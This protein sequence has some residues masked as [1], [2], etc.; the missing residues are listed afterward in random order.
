MRIFLPLLLSCLP[1]ILFCQVSFTDSTN[2]LEISNQNSGSPMGVADMNSDGLDDII[3]LDSRHLLYIHY[4]LLDTP[5]FHTEFIADLVGPKWSLCVADADANGF[6]D[7]F[8][9]G[10]YDGLYLLKANNNG[11]GFNTTVL[12]DPSIF[13]QGSNFADIDND[14]D[15]DIFACHDEGLSVPFANDGS[16]N[17]TADFNLILPESTIPSDNSGNYGSVWTDYD[18]D[19]DLDLYISKCRQGVDNPV[20][21]R[22]L[23]LLF[24][25]DGNNNYSDVATQANLQPFAQSWA[26]DFGDIDNDGDLDCF[27]IN[28]DINNTLHRN[29]GDGTFTDISLASNINAALNGAGPGLQVKFADFD[30]DGLVDLLFTSLGTSH[31]LLINNG[32]NTFTAA[33]NPF[34]EA[35]TRIHSAAVGDLNNDGFLDVYAGFGMSYNQSSDKSDRLFINDG[36]GNHY[37]KARLRGIESNINGIGAR[38]ELYGS[39]GKQIREIRSGES[40]GIMNSFTAHFGLGSATSIDSLIIRWPSGNL[41]FLVNPPADTTIFIEEGDFCLPIANFQYSGPGLALDFT[42]SGDAEVTGWQWDFGDGQTGSGQEISHTFPGE[43]VYTVCLTTSGGCGQAEYCTQVGVSCMNPLAG[44]NYGVD[45]L[46]ISFEDQSFGNPTQWLWDFGDGQASSEQNPNHGYDTIGVYFVCLTASNECSN[47]TFCEFIQA[48]C[49]SVTTAFDFDADGLSVQFIDYSSAGTNE[50]EWDFGDGAFSYEE[51]PTHDFPMTGSYEVC[52]NIRGVCGQGQYCRIIEVSCPPPEAAFNTID[53]ELAI[54]FEDISTNMPTAWSWDFGDGGNSTEEM[55]VHTYAAPGTYTACLLAGSPCGQDSI[56]QDIIVTCNAPQAG[57]T[58]INDELSATFTDTSTNNPTSLLWIVEGQDSTTGP[59]LEYDF[60]SPGN[61][62]ICLQAGS[63][64]GMTETCQTVEINCAVLQPG[65]DYQTEG[66]RLTFTDT[67]T[68]TATSW[69]WDFGDG[70]SSN[71]QDPVHDYALPGDYEVCLQISNIC[72]ETSSICRILSIDC[73][74]PEAGFSY[75]TNMLAIYLSDTSSNAPTQW[76]W[77]FGDGNSSA[78]ENPQHIYSGPGTYEVCVTAISPCGSSQACSMVVID[79]AEPVS[80]FM[81]ESNGLAVSLT[82]NSLNSPTQWLW[83]FGDNS[84]STEQNPQH[85]YSAPGNYVI[86]LVTTSV[87]GTDQGCRQVSISCI[88]PQ[89]SFSFTADGLSLSFSDQSANNPDGW[90]WTFG[91]GASSTQASPQH[92]YTSPGSYQV[93]LQASSICGMTE[94]CQTLEVSCAA[95]QPAFSFQADELSL[96][97]TDQSANNPDGWLWTFG[98]GSSSTQANPQHTYAGP[99]SYQ[100]CL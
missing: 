47:S 98:D 22:R 94:I 54:T 38:L 62:D 7:I 31:A 79:C 4:Q 93:C 21:G 9:G 96:A 20:D 27:I 13:L 12:T 71:L 90:L 87:C 73:A 64:C 99:G 85:T 25:N 15:P 88:A 92:N 11:T 68:T 91:D 67:S 58:F 60:D 80:D 37:F 52:L 43:G 3:C 97:F 1:S 78:Q 48:E 36:N 29:N 45:G 69:A 30:N 17:F 84:N 50:W 8:T 61:Y 35:P 2:R 40:Y 70:A 53:N 56:C 6:N 34:P 95:P 77:S 89:A 75:Q 14:S 82:D 18:N 57:F 55:P 24:Q 23:N 81:V 44:F 49:G 28:H 46:D 26:A 5:A 76:L 74:A 42:G 83:S 19:G 10:L 86:C 39:W 59:I 41:D 100:V 33:A 72:G 51:N 65:F 63:I 16:G 32:N 66:L